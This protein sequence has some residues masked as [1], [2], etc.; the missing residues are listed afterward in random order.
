MKVYISGCMSG[1]PSLGYPAFDAAAI[2]LRAL[3]FSVVNPAEIGR[4]YG[5]DEKAKVS[6]EDRKVLLLGDLDALAYCD[7]IFVLPGWEH[8]GGA[9]IEVRFGAYFGIPYFSSISDLLVF[10][11]GKAA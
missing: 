1:V 8:S 2:Q 9:D 6:T 7:A 4:H 10:R 5:F 3:G 11:E